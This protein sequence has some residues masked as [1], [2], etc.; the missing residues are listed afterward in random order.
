MAYP[1]SL[2]PGYE[3]EAGVN[4]QMGDAVKIPSELYSTSLERRRE[5]WEIEQLERALEES[6]QDA[7]AV[8][9]WTPRRKLSAASRRLAEPHR[10]QMFVSAT[11]G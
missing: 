2:S 11:K 7:T 9:A 6:R 5:A 8:A 10:G 1:G 3:D 4:R